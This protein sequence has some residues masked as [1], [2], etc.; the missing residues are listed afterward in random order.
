MHVFS[1]PFIFILF[2]QLM[3]DFL[4]SICFIGVGRSGSIRVCC[5]PDEFD[6]GEV[7]EAFV[8]EQLRCVLA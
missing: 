3:S 7:N 8:P 5:N 1:I 4:K 6:A 2:H